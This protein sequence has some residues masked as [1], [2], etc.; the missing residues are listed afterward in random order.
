[1]CRTLSVAALAAPLSV[2]A[3]TD[4]VAQE[5]TEVPLDAQII[6]HEPDQLD[7]DSKRY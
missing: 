7:S 6:Q 3:V 5:T 4:V 1:M 2:S